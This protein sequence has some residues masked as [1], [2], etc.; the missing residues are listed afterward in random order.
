M[1]KS[2]RNNQSNPDPYEDVVR[3]EK[4]DAYESLI[5]LDLFFKE[6]TNSKE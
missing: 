4:L 3:F 1:K 5:K 2:K 6:N